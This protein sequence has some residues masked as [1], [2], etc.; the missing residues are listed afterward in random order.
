MKRTVLKRD[1]RKFSWSAFPCEDSDLYKIRVIYNNFY[2]FDYVSPR[3]LNKVD[4]LI[5]DLAN[6]LFLTDYG[7]IN[8]TAEDYSTHGQG[9]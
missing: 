1:N 2:I 4:K 3:D 9:D 6:L 7:I 5:D 8:H